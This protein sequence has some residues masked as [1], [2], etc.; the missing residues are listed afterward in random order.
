[1]T[2][3]P[4]RALLHS[5]WKVREGS[6]CGR[7]ENMD[8]G[9]ILNDQFCVCVLQCQK[10]FLQTLL[11]PSLPQSSSH[12]LPAL[13]PVRE[14]QLASSAESAETVRKLNLILFLSDK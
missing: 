13:Q 12:P 7:Q 11:L 10:W 5:T 6:I 3:A 1:M 9:E 4:P 8:R 14:N 2:V